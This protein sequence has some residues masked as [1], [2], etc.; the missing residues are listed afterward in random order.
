M[1]DTIDLLG[2]RLGAPERL[3]P[4]VPLPIDAWLGATG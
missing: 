3:T 4:Q 2:V 1:T